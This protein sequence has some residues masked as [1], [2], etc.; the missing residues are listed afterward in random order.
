MDSHYFN[1]SHICPEVSLVTD[2]FHPEKRRGIY[3]PLKKQ[4]EI[5]Y[6]FGTF[7]VFAGLV[8]NG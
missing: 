1:L 2:L 8:H 4:I 3:S 6:K 7:A 5:M